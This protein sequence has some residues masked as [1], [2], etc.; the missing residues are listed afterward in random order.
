MSNPRNRWY[1][2]LCPSVPGHPP[3]REAFRS[4]YTP[5]PDTHGDRF[6]LVI[7]PF[8]TR[9]GAQ[10]DVRHGWIN[11]HIQTAADADRLARQYSADCDRCGEYFDP[12]HP[13]SA[14]QFCPACQRQHETEWRS[15]AVGARA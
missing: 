3:T 7:G 2:G 14:R 1:V 9:R 15:A 4:P 8:A 11:P 5:T 13:D 6:F 10:F 12:R